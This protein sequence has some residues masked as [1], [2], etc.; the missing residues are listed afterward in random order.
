MANSRLIEKDKSNYVLLGIGILFAFL[1]F[2]RGSYTG[3]MV[4]PGV[5]YAGVL[6]MLNGCI[7]MNAAGTIAGITGDQLCT[8][9]NSGIC[10]ATYIQENW[11]ALVPPYGIKSGFQTCQDPYPTLPSIVG[12]SAICCRPL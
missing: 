5:T 12:K 6:Q 3:Q 1:L 10:V 11:A 2:S 8:Q 9:S 4:R 7:V